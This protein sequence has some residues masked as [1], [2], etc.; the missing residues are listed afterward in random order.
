VLGWL[1]GV[2]GELYYATVYAYNARD[3]W[4]EGVWDYGGNGD[5]TLFYPGTPSKIGGRTQIP[6]ESL[7]LKHLRDGLEDYEYLHLLSALGDEGL[8]R[9]RARSLT[10]RAWEIEGDPAKWERVRTQITARLNALWKKSE[11]A[12]GSP[13]DG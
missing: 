6:V 4:S 11:Y 7:R 1:T 5:G 13:V 2:D 8:A 3:P 10:P 12:R 9:A